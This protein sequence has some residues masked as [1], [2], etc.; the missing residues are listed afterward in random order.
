MYGSRLDWWIGGWYW[1]VDKTCETDVAFYPI[2]SFIRIAV[3]FL[4]RESFITL[5][6]TFREREQHLF[7][8]RTC[9]IV[10]YPT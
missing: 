2:P 6:L 1:S 7:E 5:K 10:Q 3:N 8:V 4:E 9:K